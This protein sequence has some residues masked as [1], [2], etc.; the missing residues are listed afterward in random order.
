MAAKR[1]DS[2]VGSVRSAKSPRG[3]PSPDLTYFEDRGTL[4]DAPLEVVWD[5]LEKDEEFHP[6]AHVTS[7]RNFES[8]H[9]SELT[10]LI[11]CEVRWAGQWRKM[12]SRL[13]SIRPVMR[14]N[15][16][17]EGPYAGSKMAF[18]YSPR[19][20]KTAIDVLCYMHSSEHSP[21]EL[22]RQVL[23][24]LARTHA[25]DEPFLHRFARKQL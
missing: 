4:L 18:S 24:D 9:L 5:Y 15:E 17:L 7:L 14:I 3:R 8:Q 21:R 12:V 6:K 10:S 23:G 2:N 13:T 22:R 1:P 20:S 25:E 11:R 16:E 19:G